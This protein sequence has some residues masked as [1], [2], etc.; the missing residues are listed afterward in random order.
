MPSQTP[1]LLSVT[2]LFCFH[3]FPVSLG[4][5]CGVT[6]SWIAVYSSFS[7]LEEPVVFFSPVTLLRALLAFIFSKIWS[8]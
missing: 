1:V 5:S 8:N 7:A 2:F 3:V 4:V 6:V